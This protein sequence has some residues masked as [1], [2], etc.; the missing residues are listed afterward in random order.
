MSQSDFSSDGQHPERSV[1][2]QRGDTLQDIHAKHGLSSNRGQFNSFE[3]REA[4]KPMAHTVVE[5]F[6]QVFQDDPEVLEARTIK[7]VEHTRNTD[8]QDILNTWVS[9]HYM[10]HADQPW[11]SWPWSKSPLMH[12]EMPPEMNGLVRFCPIMLYDDQ[13]F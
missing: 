10:G 9:V 3:G 5:T 4:R 13:D 6:R 1:S 7:N 12:T 8:G 11:P 2:K